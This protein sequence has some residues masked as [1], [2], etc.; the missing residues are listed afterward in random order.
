MK[1]AGQLLDG[2]HVPVFRQ[3]YTQPSRHICWTELKYLMCLGRCKHSQADGQQE[4]AERQPCITGIIAELKHV[5]FLQT[6][7]HASSKRRSFCGVCS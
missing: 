5:H 1:H 6:H 3:L 7:T 4:H 2:V